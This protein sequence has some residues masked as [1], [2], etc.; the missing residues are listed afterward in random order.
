[1]RQTSHSPRD[2]LQV[3]K[4]AMILELGAM[5]YRPQLVRAMTLAGCDSTRREGKTRKVRTSADGIDWLGLPAVKDAIR[6]RS[7]IQEERLRDKAQCF[8]S[9]FRYQFY[10]LQN[11]LNR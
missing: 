6:Y 1:M 2:D 8:D 3:Y 10:E 11:R 7:D 4:F 5:E 9:Q